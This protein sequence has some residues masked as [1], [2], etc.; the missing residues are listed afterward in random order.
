MIKLGVCL[1]GC[2]GF[3]SCPMHVINILIYYLFIYMYLKSDILFYGFHIV[4]GIHYDTG[5]PQLDGYTDSDMSADVDTSR[6]T[7]GYVMTYAGGAIS[8]Q[9]RL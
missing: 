2:I 6:S 9:S 7:S 1:C 5:K 4:C 3:E 8:W